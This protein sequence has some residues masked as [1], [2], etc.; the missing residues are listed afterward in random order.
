MDVLC[1]LIAILAV[2][3]LLRVMQEPANGGLFVAE[4]AGSKLKPD[5]HMFGAAWCHFTKEQWKALS[6]ANTFD[7][8]AYAADPQVVQCDKPDLLNDLPRAAKGD[9]KRKL[10][11]TVGY[12]TVV[13]EKTLCEHL[14][15]KNIVNADC[16]Y[17]EGKTVNDLDRVVEEWASGDDVKGLWVGFDQSKVSDFQ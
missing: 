2:W 5:H 8:A 17:A 1:T 12:P 13:S 6:G 7:A 4:D 9:I 15:T 16:V 11:T 10:C 14:E 3:I